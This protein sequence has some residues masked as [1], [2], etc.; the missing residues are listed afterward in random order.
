M[1]RTQFGRLIVLM[2]TILCLFLLSASAQQSGKKEFTFHGKVEKVD[3]KAKTLTVDGE[4]V[5]GWMDAMTMAYQVDKQD[6]FERIRP[7][8]QITAK[9]YD[10]DFKMLHD[11]RVTPAKDNPAPKKK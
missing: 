8:D 7:G 4:K 9:V 10:N 11:V 1:A 5:E 6:V 2:T 3:S